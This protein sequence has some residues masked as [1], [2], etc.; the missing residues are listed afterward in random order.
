MADVDAEVLEGEARS[1]KELLLA[2]I[3]DAVS[4]ILYY[5]RKEDEELSAEDVDAL[6]GWGG[7]TLTEMVEAFRNA[8][9]GAFPDISE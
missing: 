8:V 1:K 6:I 2:S 9:K 5:D 3:D 4:D 7:V